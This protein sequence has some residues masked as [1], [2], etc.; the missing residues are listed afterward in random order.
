MTSLD[1]LRAAL[2]KALDGHTRGSRDCNLSG[3]YLTQ[4]IWP[5]VEAHLSAPEGG[6]KDYLSRILETYFPKT[7]KQPPLIQE[8]RAALASPSTPGGVER[9][10][11]KYVYAKRWR[12]LI[13][14]PESIADQ[15]RDALAS[16]PISGERGELG[17]T[18]TELEATVRDLV[19][20][21][22]RLR[23][24]LRTAIDDLSALAP[25]SDTG[26]MR[27]RKI[28]AAVARAES[29]LTAPSAS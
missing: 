23:A 24:G 26:S 15:V 21:N 27:K 16:R 4:Q 2:V 12:T 13:H 1:Q 19:T 18:I 22:E 20:R 28:D 29:A 5:L 17:A 8:A 14:V 7:G 25:R 11:W 3:E 10:G 6:W 9:P